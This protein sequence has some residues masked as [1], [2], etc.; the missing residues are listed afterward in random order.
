MSRKIGFL[1]IILVVASLP[2]NFGCQNEATESREDF[3]QMQKVSEQNIE[4]VDGAFNPAS[5]SVGV[6]QE[7][8]W[9]NRD[10]VTHTVTIDNGED[11]GN[12]LAKEIFPTTFK[13]PGTYKYHCKIHPN[14][15]GTITVK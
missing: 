9:I 14:M 12:I 4:I 10:T 1:L 6:D 3:T 13:K 15:T 7:L 5:Y 8:T 11:S 2:V